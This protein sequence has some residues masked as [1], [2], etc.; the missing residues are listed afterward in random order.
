MHVVH[1]CSSGL[2]GSDSDFEDLVV[3]PDWVRQ[4]REGTL[5]VPQQFR[6]LF[7]A[8]YAA[9]AAG[10]AAAPD[11]SVAAAADAAADAAE[12]AAPAGVADVVEAPDIDPALVKAERLRRL[13]RMGSKGSFSLRM[14]LRLLAQHDTRLQGMY[15][16][17]MD[18][19]DAWWK[20]EKNV[21]GL[22]NMLKTGEDC[23]RTAQ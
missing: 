22:L 4:L 16:S 3:M 13:Y 7:E 17:W 9:A 11:S 1:I 6:T 10:Q 20:A 12:L 21:K 19:M 5:Q 18:S 15:E 14:T 23:Q 2:T 8:P